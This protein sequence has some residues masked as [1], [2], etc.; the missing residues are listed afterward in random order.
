MRENRTYG[1]MRGQGR[2]S[3]P[4][5]STLLEGRLVFYQDKIRWGK[6][7]VFK[8]I[9]EEIYG[10]FVLQD[11]KYRKQNLSVLKFILQLKYQNWNLKCLTI[12]GIGWE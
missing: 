1:L 3:N 8:R 10:H 12:T 2:V 9:E 4:S 11:I 6:W 5:R 7:P